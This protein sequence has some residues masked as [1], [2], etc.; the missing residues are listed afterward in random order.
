MK[1]EILNVCN[2][3][4][5]GAANGVYQ[6]I[7]IALLVALCLRFLVRTN[8]ATRHGVWFCTLLLLVTLVIAHCL[9]DSASL[10]RATSKNTSPDSSIESAMPVTLPNSVR[11]TVPTEDGSSRLTSLS[12]DGANPEPH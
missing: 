9:V 7:I 1:N 12:D 8:A 11:S 6:G 4:V 3:L 5:A 2:Q 10:R